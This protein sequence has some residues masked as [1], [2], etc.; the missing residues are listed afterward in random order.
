MGAA[1]SEPFA[2]TEC[3][4]VKNLERYLSLYSR[5]LIT[6]DEFSMEV[7]VTLA[8][9]QHHDPASMLQRVPAD[10]QQAILDTMSKL[11]AKDYYWVLFLIGD[12]RTPQQKH[13]DALRLQP[14][15]RRACE[16]VQEVLAAGD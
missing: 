2:K 7:L 1:S 9:D 11:A 15:L 12:T 3:H 6:R 10:V 4:A 16:S 14:M 5:G 13:E 8:T